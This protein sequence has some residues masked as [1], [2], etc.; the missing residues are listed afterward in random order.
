MQKSL[1]QLK[2]KMKMKDII[3]L[4][5]RNGL[6]FIPIGENSNGTEMAFSVSAIGTEKIAEGVKLLK[7]LIDDSDL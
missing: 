5:E 1:I 4:C 6:T 3:S 2:S 7:K